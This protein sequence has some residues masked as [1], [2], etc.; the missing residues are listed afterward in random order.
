[1]MRISGKDYPTL[2]DAA[3][4]FGVAAKTVREWIKKRII[5]HPPRINHGARKIDYF[6]TEYMEK[7]KEELKQYRIDKTPR[8]SSGEE[9]PLFPSHEV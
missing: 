9:L 6:P 8:G 2:S 1:M 3:A 7:A 4:I 5:S